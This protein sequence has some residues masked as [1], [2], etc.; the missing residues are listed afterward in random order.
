MARNAGRKSGPKAKGGGRPTTPSSPP[1]RGGVGDAPAGESPFANIMAAEDAALDPE[2]DRLAVRRPT[3]LQGTAKRMSVKQSDSLQQIADSTVAAAYNHRASPDSGTDLYA[4]AFQALDDAARS[5]LLG[6]MDAAD[7]ELVVRVLGGKKVLDSSQPAAA[8]AKPMSAAQRAKERAREALAEQGLEEVESVNMDTGEPRVE[9]RRAR[10]AQTQP[11]AASRLTPTSFEELSPDAQRAVALGNEIQDAVEEFER[12]NPDFLDTPKGQILADE[13]FSLLEAH[14]ES[15]AFIEDP[16]LM[17]R[18]MPPIQDAVM[19]DAG[20]AALPE[21]MRLT[22]R[23]GGEAR[24]QMKLATQ[25]ERRLGRYKD[26]PADAPNRMAWILLKD[27]E[28]ASKQG[29]SLDTYRRMQGTKRLTDEDRAAQAAGRNP[30]K[31]FVAG[32]EVYLPSTE[33]IAQRANR[34]RKGAQANIDDVVGSR[35]SIRRSQD[36]PPAAELSAERIAEL[37]AAAEAARQRIASGKND[38][39]ATPVEDLTQ[40]PDYYKNIR[41]VERRPLP[42]SATGSPQQVRFD[43]DYALREGKP[44]IEKWR[45]KIFRLAN[46]SVDPEKV[47]V[48]SRGLMIG[49]RSGPGGAVVA[50]EIGDDLRA[51]AVM[52]ELGGGEPIRTR[53][54]KGKGPRDSRRSTPLPLDF[55]IPQWRGYIQAVDGGAIK[56]RRPNAYEVAGFILDQLDMPDAGMA[57]RLESHVQLAMDALEPEVPTRARARAAAGTVFEPNNSYRRIMEQEAYEARTPGDNRPLYDEQSALAAQE[58]AS[59]A[60]MDYSDEAKFLPAS[61]APSGEVAP[62]QQQFTLQQEASSGANAAD[63]AGGGPPKMGEAESA[64]S[65]LRKGA[66]G[67]G[68]PTNIA[69]LLALTAAGMAGGSAMAGEDGGESPQVEY[70]AMARSPSRV[71]AKGTRARKPA[72]PPPNL[73]PRNAAP[74]P[75]PAPAPAQ[76]PLPQPAATPAPAPTASGQTAPTAAPTPAPARQPMFPDSPTARAVGPVVGFAG[77]H[78]PDIAALAAGGVS[79]PFLVGLARRGVNYMTEPLQPAPAA[80]DAKAELDELFKQGIL[81]PADQRATPMPPPAAPAMNQGSSNSIETL[82]SMLNPRRMV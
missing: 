22:S 17:T 8:P 9:V 56:T 36:S 21:G 23:I 62:G 76:N 3:V 46:E 16:G 59:K 49:D 67:G 53:A 64:F 11:I 65:R 52:E 63:G 72:S 39:P 54:G 71:A 78:I 12:W 35:S 69:T 40:D 30:R 58:A 45:E 38:A 13:M 32:V 74:A 66:G 31:Q 4:R 6:A 77:R 18:Q 81:M 7:A 25:G 1:L 60:R 47:G 79:L 43:R 42:G 80:S 41:Q 37:D 2:M 33:E 57:S 82:R 5:R 10:Q 19:P 73:P 70:L 28:E 20:R 75:S 26:I 24:A 15:Q 50:N 14:P 55:L 27:A 48:G 61:D 44:D 34:G 29:V 68:S 51:S